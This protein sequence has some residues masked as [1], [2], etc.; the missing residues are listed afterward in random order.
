MTRSQII[1]KISNDTGL[2]KGRVEKMFSAFIEA[3]G[4]A[5]R[6]GDKV[7]IPGFGT[8]LPS[9]RRQREGVSPLDSTQRI[10]IPKHTVPRFKPSQQLR[11][12][13]NKN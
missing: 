1:K 11:V 9:P 6:G 3:V 5:L 12:R 10:V 7:T 2:P 4:E 8:F 13:F